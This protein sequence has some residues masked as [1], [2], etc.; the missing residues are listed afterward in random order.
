MRKTNCFPNRYPWPIE[1][2]DVYPQPRHPRPRPFPYPY[3][4]PTDQW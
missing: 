2:P 1:Y 3:P 4:R